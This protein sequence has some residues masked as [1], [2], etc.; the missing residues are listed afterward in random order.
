MCNLTISQSLSASLAFDILLICGVQTEK[1]TIIFFMKNC[2]MQ[3]YQKKIVRWRIVCLIPFDK[4]IKLCKILQ[5]SS[6]RYL[7]KLKPSLI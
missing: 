1:N 2:E 5:I 3:L 7:T 4:K 6:R